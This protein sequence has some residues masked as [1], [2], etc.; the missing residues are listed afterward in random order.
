[1]KIMLFQ[2]GALIDSKDGAS[3][4]TCNMANEFCRRGHEAVLI[5]WE[6]KNGTPYYDLDSR[7]LFKNLGVG[8]ESNSFKGKFKA[9]IHSFIHQKSK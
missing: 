4:V 1:M 2:A 5:G 8:L 7:I 3:K 6:N 9:L